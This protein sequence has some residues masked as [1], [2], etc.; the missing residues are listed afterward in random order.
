MDLQ[1][2][3]DFLTAEISNLKQSIKELEGVLADAE[4]KKIWLEKN[5]E[6]ILSLNE[7]RKKQEEIKAEYE[8]H[9]DQLAIVIQQIQ[10]KI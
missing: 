8:K 1:Q 9:L 4:E 6:K 7:D 3:N 5:Q 2:K 10:D